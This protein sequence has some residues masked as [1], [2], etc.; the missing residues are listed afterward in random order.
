M[1]DGGSGGV[2]LDGLLDQMPD[3]PL[4]FAHEFN[5]LLAG[6]QGAVELARMEAASPAQQRLE[7]V[8]RAVVLVAEAT[9]DR[10]ALA[11]HHATTAAIEA[12][13][14]DPTG[15]AACLERAREAAPERGARPWGWITIC[16]A[17]VDLARS[18]AGDADAL[19]AVEAV[20]ATPQENA[21]GRALARALRQRTDGA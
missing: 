3:D 1:D 11:H 13:G 17:W 10:L 19:A 16:G 5:K 2:R 6:I 21:F 18:Q 7:V 14:G 9:D 4:L 8:E 20:L 15:A 12:A